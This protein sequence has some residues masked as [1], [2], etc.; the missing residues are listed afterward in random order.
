MSTTGRPSCAW[1]TLIQR[2][3]AVGF[4]LLALACSCGGWLDEYIPRKEVVTPVLQMNVDLGSSE[5]QSGVFSVE[6]PGRYSVNARLE[7]RHGPRGTV[8]DAAKFR[9]AGTASISPIRGTG[10]TW[11]QNFE[12]DL[13]A[14]EIGAQLFEIEMDDPNVGT[15]Q[16]FRISLR[17]SPEFREHYSA[18]R[19]FIRRELKHPIMY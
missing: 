4:P 17:V 13:T 11:N 10:E 8:V 16:R 15:E 18:M 14:A 12:M 5:A 19:V 6:S 3:V 9:L 7:L 1:N 2:L